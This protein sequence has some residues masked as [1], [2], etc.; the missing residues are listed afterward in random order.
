MHFAVVQDVGASDQQ[1]D[2][3]VLVGD[4]DGDV[5]EPAEVADGDA[6]VPWTPD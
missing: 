5:A 3:A 2:F 6:P 4:A 1:P